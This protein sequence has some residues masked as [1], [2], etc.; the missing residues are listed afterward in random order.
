MA[1]RIGGSTRRTSGG[2]EEQGGPIVSGPLV[3][4]QPLWPTIP[5]PHE[6]DR[7]FAQVF[8]LVGEGI[9]GATHALLAGD[10]EAA[11]ELVQ[12][13]DVIDRIIGEI[14]QS[15][16][17]QLVHGETTADERREL[18]AVL[19]MLPDMERNG[20]LAEHI[21]RRAARGLGAEM[22]ARSRGLVERM[23]EVATT[24]WRSTADAFA[25][26]SATAANQIDDLDDELDDL[27]VTLTAELVA[28][29]MP[30]PVAIELAMVAR[31]Y[32]RFGDHAV[33]LARRLSALVLGGPEP[34]ASG[35]D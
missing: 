20:D 2:D 21:A 5:E 3:M 28:G 27:H 8:A 29:T 33:N 23:G 32:E 11:K 15:V 30:L 35:P 7:L 10:R 16:Q 24:I 17:H 12:R 22:S 1:F 31:F 18:V 14:S 6:V 19:R 13:D 9:A 34:G 4:E 26:R 25:E